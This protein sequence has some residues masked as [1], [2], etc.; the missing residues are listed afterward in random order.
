MAANASASADVHEALITRAR[1]N[2][3]PNHVVVG[4]GKHETCFSAHLPKIMVS[5]L[6]E[7][8]ARGERPRVL[9]V[10]RSKRNCESARKHALKGLAEASAWRSQEGE[11]APELS[12]YSSGVT[13]CGA[14]RVLSVARGLVLDGGLYVY[15]DHVDYFDGVLDAFVH[16]VLHPL[17]ESGKGQNRLV[18]TRFAAYE[19]PAVVTKFVESANAGVPA[20]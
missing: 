10:G 7:A 2:A 9:Y 3:L 20:Q 17:L 5:D 18:K 6:L 1:E 16:D 8:A 12:D 11:K 4:H 13:W 14:G 15:A 19:T